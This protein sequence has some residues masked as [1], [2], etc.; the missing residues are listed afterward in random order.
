MKAIIKPEGAG[1]VI[2]F[3]GDDCPVDRYF[4][5]ELELDLGRELGVVPLFSKE[6]IALL[7][8]EE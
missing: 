8:E 5:K 1:W 7:K 6:E 4:V 2:E 3:C